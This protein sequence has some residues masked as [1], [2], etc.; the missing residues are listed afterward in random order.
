M[1]GVVL[2]LDLCGSI[3]MVEAGSKHLCAAGPTCSQGSGSVSPSQTEISSVCVCVC[4]GD[5]EQVEGA[6]KITIRVFKNITLVH[7]SGMVLLEVSH[8]NSS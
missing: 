5:V 6:A 2:A 1:L 4:V 7:D 3:R 8:C